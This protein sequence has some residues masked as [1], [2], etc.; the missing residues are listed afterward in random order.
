MYGL[1]VR[2][3]GAAYAKG[4][5]APSPLAAT[6]DATPTLDDVAAL[7]RGRRVL[8]LGGA[9]VS[10]ESGIPDYRGP[11]SSKVPRNPMRFQEFVGSEA[12]RRRYWSRSFVGWERIAAARPNAAHRALV[13]LEAGGHAVGLITQNVDGLHQ[14]AGS[15]RVL[16]LH[17]SLA[18]VRCLGCSAVS[19]RRALQLRLRDLN[20]A[21][22]A[23]VL[24]LAPDG[25]AELAGEH[26]AAF[27][28]PPCGRCGGVLKPDVVFF[29]ENVPKAR[30]E[31]AYA[32]LASADALLVV[33]SSLTVFSGYRFVVRAVRDAKPVVIL[34]QGETRG[35]A[36][37]ALKLSGRLGEVLPALAEQLAC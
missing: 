17:G 5:I 22:T 31:R 15:R 29:G 32:A 2:R 24:G 36:D 23:P 1:L 37:A 13:G 9:G 25:D 14:A 3:P 10:T 7:L 6:L 28:V 27:R 18:A 26:E 4:V 11:E 12:A 16:E 19:S 20:P 34:N 8:V 21:T 30:V 35:D 33:G